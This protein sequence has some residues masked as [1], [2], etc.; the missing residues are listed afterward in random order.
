MENDQKLN[1]DWAI[2]TMF[3]FERHISRMQYVLMRSGLWQFKILYLIKV[4]NCSNYLNKYY[5]DVK[6]FDG[7]EIL[8]AFRICVTSKFQLEGF[9]LHGLEILLLILRLFEG[10]MVSKVS[11]YFI[12][13]QISYYKG[14]FIVSLLE[15]ILS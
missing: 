13:I 9:C 15:D 5:K 14:I 6:Y 3:C 4:T 11:Y 8:Q 1:H 7:T 12:L 10:S 2:L